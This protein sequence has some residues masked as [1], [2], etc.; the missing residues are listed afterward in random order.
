MIQCSL[1][2]NTTKLQCK[3]KVKGKISASAGDE[4]QVLCTY[5]KNKL[6]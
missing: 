3:F 4:S 5:H 6:S 1:I 2:S